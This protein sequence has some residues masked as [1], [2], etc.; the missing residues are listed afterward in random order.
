MNDL[1]GTLPLFSVL[2][3][4]STYNQS[5]YITDA[6]NG[7]VMQQIV[8]IKQL[9]NSFVITIYINLNIFLTKVYKSLKYI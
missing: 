8:I 3:R 1:F 6:L 4:C 7:F 2:V 5:K 9:I